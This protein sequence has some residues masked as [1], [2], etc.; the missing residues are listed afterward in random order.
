MEEKPQTDRK[1]EAGCYQQLNPIWACARHL[2]K[3]N[4]FLTSPNRS[5]KFYVK[6]D[7]LRQP[8]YQSN[9]FWK[10]HNM[11]TTILSSKLK[12]RVN[13]GIHLSEKTSSGWKGW[14]RER[15]T[16][17]VIFSVIWRVFTGRHIHGKWR[18]ALFSNMNQFQELQYSICIILTSLTI[19]PEYL[20]AS[21]S[22]NRPFH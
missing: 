7:V 19:N 6:H 1:A 8:R 9:F 21:A 20:S 4:N 17:W 2:R 18:N 16:G 12:W 11:F 14:D 15:C 22:M 5:R 10:I 3:R 13:V